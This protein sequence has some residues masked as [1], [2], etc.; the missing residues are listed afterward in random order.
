M[1][2]IKDTL[3]K[4]REVEIAPGVSITKIIAKGEKGYDIINLSPTEFKVV[5]RMAKGL[6]NKEIADKMG[7]S[8]R[9]IQTHLTNIYRKLGVGSRTESILKLL[10]MGILTIDD[11]KEDNQ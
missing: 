8:E 5:M 4:L 9:T 6:R 10:T 7:T 3:F 1:P 2:V 11:L